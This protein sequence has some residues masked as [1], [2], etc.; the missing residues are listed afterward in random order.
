MCRW[1]CTEVVSRPSGDGSR[2]GGVSPAF[3]HPVAA[4]EA[5]PP[6]LDSASEAT[7]VEPAQC[8]PVLHA[9]AAATAPAQPTAAAERPIAHAYAAQR[10]LLRADD[11]SL[12]R[13]PH[14]WALA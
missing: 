9:A 6:A 10:L 11:A 14:D 13:R 8:V 3:P 1:V 5:A 7:A 4:A 2:S 12:C